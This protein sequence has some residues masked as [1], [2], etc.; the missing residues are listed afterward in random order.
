MWVQS[1]YNLRGALR[2]QH[3]AQLRIKEGKDCLTRTRSAF[4]RVDM[5]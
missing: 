2:L 1:R 5:A 3:R 4:G